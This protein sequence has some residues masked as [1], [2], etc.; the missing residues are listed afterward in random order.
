[1]KATIKI[2]MDNAAFEPDFNVE[3]ARLLEAVAARIRDVGCSGAGSKRPISDIN[4]NLV[5]GLAISK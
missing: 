3:L 2:N 4:G 1:M 5:G